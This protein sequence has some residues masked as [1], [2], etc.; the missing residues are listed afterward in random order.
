MFCLARR[1]C[2]EV[3]KEHNTCSG[4]LPAGAWNSLAA[5]AREGLARR[6]SSRGNRR[7]GEQAAADEDDD[8][9]E[10][11]QEQDAALGPAP[12]DSPG[13][14]TLS[15][16]LHHFLLTGRP[17]EAAQIICDELQRCQSA[18]SSGEGG[19][20]GSGDGGSGG[21]GRDGGRGSSS[22]GSSNAK[23]GTADEL[24]DVVRKMRTRG[25]QVTT[26]GTPGGDPPG[27][28]R[29]CTIY[30]WDRASSTD[31]PGGLGTT[32]GAGLRSQTAGGRGI[33][34]RDASTSAANSASSLPAPTHAAPR[35][36][37]AYLPRPPLPQSS[38][39]PCCWLR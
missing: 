31:G 21:R 10:Q 34:L 32:L 17:R 29:G 15:S 3:E 7:A 14:S 16:R 37:P 22:A 13:G 8:E 30:I 39:E 5:V 1:L 33:H 23:A 24:R 12:T 19:G 11:E 35:G 38:S 26:A 36:R 25:L 2:R 18:L 20:G 28:G 27:G 6:T 9:D 4:G